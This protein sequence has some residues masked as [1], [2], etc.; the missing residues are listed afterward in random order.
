MECNGNIRKP[1]AL[2]SLPHSLL[3]QSK[4]RSTLLDTLSRLLI[5]VLLLLSPLPLDQDGQEVPQIELWPHALEEVDLGVLMA[6]P[7]H[8]V[9]QSLNTAC[10]NKHV[11]RR[12]SS[13]IHVV[14]QCFCRDALRIWVSC[15]IR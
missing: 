5:H 13:G 3:S 12:V 9:A 11:Q 15:T 4:F 6:L 2:A 14:R 1:K 7:Q 10:P 8:E